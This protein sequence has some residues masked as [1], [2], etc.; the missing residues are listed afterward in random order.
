MATLEFQPMS[1]GQI[2]DRTFTL[3]RR[4][5]LHYIAIVAVAV[6]PFRVLLYL[7]MVLVD[8]MVG[9]AE[10]EAQSA[11]AVMMI[12]TGII[13]MIIAA[14]A[15]ALAR[16]ALLRAVSGSYLGE[17]V[18][19]GQ[20]YRKAL[21]RLW[22][23]LVAGFLVGIITWLG[24]LLLIVPGVIFAAAFALTIPG[25]VVEDLGATEGMGRSWHL[26]RGNRSKVLGLLLLVW[27]IGLVVGATLGF[28]GGFVAAPLAQ[29]NDYVGSVVEDLF[30]MVAIVLTTPIGATATILLYYD[31]RIRKEGFDLEMLAERMGTD[32]SVD[33]ASGP[34]R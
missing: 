10:N 32:R 9:M 3:Y 12:V 24:L 11:L 25:I 7:A 4:N 27:L 16:A 22:S 33:D 19:L 28:A 23:I 29:M 8:D 30:S 14:I 13:G 15:Q 21:P 17:D 34:A 31:L 1:V 2:L 26:T 5:F 20:A 6:V 18:S